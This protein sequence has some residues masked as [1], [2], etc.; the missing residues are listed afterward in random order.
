V[1]GEDSWWWRQLSNVLKERC[2]TGTRTRSKGDLLYIV[3][4]NLFREAPGKE[5]GTCNVGVTEI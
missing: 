3:K 1:I 4:A 2:R 5:K